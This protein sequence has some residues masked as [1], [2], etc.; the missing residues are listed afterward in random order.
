MVIDCRLNLNSGFA[1]TP[2]ILIRR[3]RRVPSGKSVATTRRLHPAPNVERDI[4]SS[5]NGTVRRRA[6]VGN[7]FNDE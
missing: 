4:R 6:L 2:F 7:A 5:N 1:G 3:A